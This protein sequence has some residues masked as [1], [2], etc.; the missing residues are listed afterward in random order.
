MKWHTIRSPPSK[1][2]EGKKFPLLGVETLI[3]CIIMAYMSII[4]DKNLSFY[5]QTAYFCAQRMIWVPLATTHCDQRQVQLTET[6]STHSF[7]SSELIFHSTTS[8]FFVL[9]DTW[10][11]FILY[12]MT[13][14]QKNTPT[15]LKMRPK[16]SK[17]GQPC[18]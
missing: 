13:F 10:Q 2:V 14:V 6:T 17:V 12:F 11:D 9:I 3:F 18:P 4:M 16:S 5:L 7:C 8:S 15:C 1:C